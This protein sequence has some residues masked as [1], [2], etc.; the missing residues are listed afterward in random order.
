M[1]QEKEDPR[2]GP[3][4]RE[5][6][7]SGGARKRRRTGPARATYLARADLLEKDIDQLVDKVLMRMTPWQLETR[8]N[9]N[10]V[11]FV[12]TEQQRRNPLWNQPTT[13]TLL[14][15]TPRFIPKA[16]SLSD[17]EVHG[18]CARLGFRLVRAFERF[19]RKDYHKL[20]NEA[21][22]EAGIQKWTPKQRSLSVEH[23][24]SYVSRFFKCTLYGGGCWQGNQM[25]S[26][27]FEKCV[28]NLE[29]DIVAVAAEARKSLT[30][31][32]RWPNITQAERYAISRIVA[33]DVG[34]NMADKNFGP[35]VYSRT[36]FNEQCR[37]HLEDSKG[38]YCRI[39]NQSR[40]D[41]LEEVLSKLRMIL[42]PFKR[43][44]EAWKI[45]CES[46]IRDAIEAAKTGRLCRFYIIWKLHKAA[47]ASGL[48]SRPIAAA[49][50]YVTGPASHF[51]HCQLQDAV[52]RH[53][54]VLKDSLDLIRIVEGLRFESAEQVVLT[55]AD[56]NALY[57]S[58]QLERGMAALRW[59][60]DTHTSFNQTLKD[61]CLRLAHFVLTNNYVVCEELGS[62]IYRQHIGTAMGTSFSVVYAVIF[63]I[64]LETPII[65]DQRFSPFIRLYKRFIDDLFLIWT[66]PMATLC[67]LRKALASADEAISL[68]WSGYK[69]QEDAVN[70]VMVVAKC[71]TQVNFLDLDMSVERGSA[72]TQMNTTLGV[73][74]RPY[75]KPGN[76]YA[77]L[78]FTSFHGRHTFRGWILAE[79]LRI[80]THSSTPEVWLEEG[81]AFYHWLIARGYP[82]WYL[83]TVFLEVTWERRSQILLRSKTKSSNFFETYRACVLTLRNAPEWP[84]L[85]ER[86]DLKLTELVEST[87]RDIFPPRAFLAQS[88]APR[89]GSILKR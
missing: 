74:F 15:K 5:A 47:N 32:H 65:N 42:I 7:E 24:R 30:A 20:R 21:Q 79:L 28:D 62:A 83:R 76:A 46:I 58:I 26:P 77:Y 6:C 22:R 19:V 71:H 66:G 85:R 17:L 81:Q 69:V 67:E 13:L 52:W 12:L 37:L 48:R 60:M 35:V 41:I 43:Q 36:L 78:P 73:T 75:R 70:P 72:A 9:H 8:C 39:D 1:A 14:G 11:H 56:V 38:T 86:L 53:Q 29:R 45:V 10:L 59:F 27:S 61:L 87:F 84:Q 44:G 23:C 33:T 31:R 55:A 40:E 63:M 3:A 80:L 51:L 50:D 64:R 88:N 49:L 34:F 18:A 25:L 57:P 89:L 54:H 82:R 68:D 16:R 2:E 4:L